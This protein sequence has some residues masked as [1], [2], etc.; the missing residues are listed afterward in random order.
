[1]IIPPFTSQYLNLTKNSSLAI[2]VGYPDLFNVARTIFN[3]SGAAIQVF[4][5]IMATYLTISLL[6]SL[7][8]NW[9]NKRVALVER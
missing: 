7:L 3:Q 9:Y 5:M 2:A 1:V 4:V 6:T 8:M